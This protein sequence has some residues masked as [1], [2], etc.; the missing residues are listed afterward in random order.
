MS[1]VGAKTGLTSEEREEAKKTIRDSY[2]RNQPQEEFYSETLKV[3]R[4][5]KTNQSK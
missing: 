4:E 3:A 1:D 5:A 2:Q